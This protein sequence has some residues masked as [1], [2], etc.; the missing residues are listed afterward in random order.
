VVNARRDGLHKL[1]TKLA[2]TFGTVV[3]E[4]LNVAGMLRN[5]RLAAAISDAGFGEIR[6]QLGYKTTWTGGR[7]VVA[8]RWHPSS[9]TCS[10][11][12]AVKP[13]LRLSERSY[14]CTACGLVL[15]RDLNA[16]LNLEAVAASL[17]AGSGPE[18]VN[19][20]GADR[21]TRPGGQV[22]AKREPG[23]APA[24]QTGTVEPQGSTAVK[25]PAHAH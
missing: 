11:C 17:V 18:T 9:K 10:A 23:T 25:E 4:D 16:A 14:R 12:G 8:D 6:R 13:K 7:L 22:A 21:K 3:V 5:R 1:T 2:A 19:A 15:D 20:R 24:G